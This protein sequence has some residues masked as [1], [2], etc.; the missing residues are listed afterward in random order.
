MIFNLDVLKID[1]AQQLEKL[2]KFIVEQVNVVFRR[3]G[4]IVG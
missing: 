3:K 2:S 4:V 1:P